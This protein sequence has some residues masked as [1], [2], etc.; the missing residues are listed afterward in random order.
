MNDPYD[1]GNQQPPAPDQRTQGGVITGVLW[2]VVAVAV[3]LN[4]VLSIAGHVVISAVFGTIGVIAG[5]TLLV[6]YLKGRRQ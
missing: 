5:V 3:G 6:R 4:T 1:I 2:T